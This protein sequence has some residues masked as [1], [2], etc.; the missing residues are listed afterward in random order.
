MYG[1]PIVN[2]LGAHYTAV[3]NV[4][5]ELATDLEAG[6]VYQFACSTTCFIKQGSVTQTAAA[7]ADNALIPAGVPVYIHGSHGDHLSVIRTAADGYATLHLV[8]EI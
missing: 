2:T 6:K 1:K 4:T 7:A 5:A 3:T 8:D